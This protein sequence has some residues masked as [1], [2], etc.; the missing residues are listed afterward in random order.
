M[1]ILFLLRQKTEDASNIIFIIRGVYAMK[2]KKKGSSNNSFKI[3]RRRKRTIAKVRNERVEIMPPKLTASQLAD[4]IKKFTPLMEVANERIREILEHDYMSLAVKRVQE[5]QKRDYFD[6]FDVNTREDL[7]SRVTAIRVF[8]ADEGS[9][10]EGARKE[11]L[12]T[13]YGGKFGNEYNNKQN[14]FA[15]YDI[16]AI[17]KEKAE[18]AFENY[19]K[20]EEQWAALIGRQG[21]AGVYGSENLIIAMYDAEVR[22]IDSFDVGKDLL[23]EFEKEQKTSWK[24]I[25]DEAETTIAISGVY[26]DNLTRGLNF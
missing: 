16:S 25:E 9:T 3:N 20:L 18:K 6:M 15:R 14:K 22:G 1:R 10:L 17:D 4:Y 13:L 11:T 26:F 21:G 8:L 7:I 2:G 5:Q 19:R 23:E 12:Q 24:P